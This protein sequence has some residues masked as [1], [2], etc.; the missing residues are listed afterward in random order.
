MIWLPGTDGFGHPKAI[1]FTLMLTGKKVSLEIQEDVLG[2]R[3]TLSCGWPKTV[4]QKLH[5]YVKP[6]SSFLMAH[7]YLSFAFLWLV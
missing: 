3:V 4:R 7:C 6:V 2:W 5:S 1:G